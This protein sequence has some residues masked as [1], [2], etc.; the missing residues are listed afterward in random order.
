M[1]GKICACIHLFSL[2]NQYLATSTNVPS[3]MQCSVMQPVNAINHK[4]QIHASAKARVVIDNTVMFRIGNLNNYCSTNV[5]KFTVFCVCLIDGWLLTRRLYGYTT[6]S[7]Y[8]AMS[9]NQIPPDLDLLPAPKGTFRY[10]FPFQVKW[11]SSRF[12]QTSSARVDLS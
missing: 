1:K 4:T 7:L 10:N 9:T 11:S 8:E 5:I 3:M 6:D 12:P 2:F